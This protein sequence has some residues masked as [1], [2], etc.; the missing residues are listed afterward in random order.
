MNQNCMHE[1][2]R[3]R[4]NS[5]NA[6]YH[7]CLLSR[8]EKVYH[9]NEHIQG[10][11]LKTCSIK[12]QGVLGFSIFVSVFPYPAISEVCTGKPASVGG[13][14][15]FVP[16]GLTISFDTILYLILCCSLL[17]CYGCQGF[18]GGPIL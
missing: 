2:I 8:N 12:A 4:L 17:I 16:G 13:F 15:P 18:S 7:S 6:C 9:H 3:S 14:Y 11:G 10:L 1:D 5:G